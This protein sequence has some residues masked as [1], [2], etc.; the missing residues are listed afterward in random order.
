MIIA[1]SGP[2]GSGKTTVAERFG[3]AHGFEMIVAGAL[4]RERAEDYGMSLEK[5]GRYAEEHPDVDRDLDTVIL[6]R[7][8]GADR[9][10]GGEVREGREEGDPGEG[11][12]RA[13]PL[14]EGVRD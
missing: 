8:R 3:K 2:P 14:L 6:K 1:I 7:A 5:F 13:R 12:V 4:F 10:S 11:A 9:G